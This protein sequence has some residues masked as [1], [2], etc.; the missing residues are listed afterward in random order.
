MRWSKGL[1][2]R[3]RVSRIVRGIRINS[4]LRLKVN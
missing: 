4:M 1:S 3:Y 2:R